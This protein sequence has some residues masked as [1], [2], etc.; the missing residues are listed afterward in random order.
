METCIKFESNC[1]KQ[2]LK[3]LTGMMLKRSESTPSGEAPPRSFM[4]PGYPA[5]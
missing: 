1:L 3:V 5:K 2:V 4:K